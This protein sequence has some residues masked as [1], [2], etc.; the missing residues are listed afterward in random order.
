MSEMELNRNVQVLERS[1][2]RMRS[3]SQHLEV[4][5]TNILSASVTYREELFSQVTS[6]VWQYLLLEG[7]LRNAKLFIATFVFCR[8]PD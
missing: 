2:S 6:K 8:T 7:I 3:W 1:R 4:D 5:I